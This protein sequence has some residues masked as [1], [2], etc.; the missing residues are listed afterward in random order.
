[1]G[2]EYKA[3]QIRM[4]RHTFASLTLMNGVDVPIKNG[5]DTKISKPLCGISYVVY[6]MRYIILLPHHLQEQSNKINNKFVLDQLYKNILSTQM[7][8]P[9]VLLGYKSVHKTDLFD[10]ISKKRKKEA[11]GIEP[12]SEIKR[13]WPLRA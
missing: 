4:M 12:T 5:R 11:V 7:S 8:T 9:L 6:H 13:H 1:M 2:E 10:I 3:T